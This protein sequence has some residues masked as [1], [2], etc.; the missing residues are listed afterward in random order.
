M[1]FCLSMIFFVSDL[2]FGQLSVGELS[3]HRVSYNIC[4]R[5]SLFSILIWGSLSGPS[6]KKKNDTGE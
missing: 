1:S 6:F 5:F 2:L 3:C 4:F